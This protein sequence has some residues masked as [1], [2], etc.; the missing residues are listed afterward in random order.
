MKKIK[1][2]PILLFCIILTFIKPEMSGIILIAGIVVYFI[3][4]ARASNKEKK[5]KCI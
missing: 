5:I 2:L 4:R 1:F 3:M